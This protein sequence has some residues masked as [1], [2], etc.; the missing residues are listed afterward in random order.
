MKLKECIE[1]G[2]ECGLE[3]I[4]E[5]ILNVELHSASLF[6]I[7]NIAKEISELYNDLLKEEPNIFQKIINERNNTK[8]E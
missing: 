2:R 7:D 8:D 4:E 5:C 6:K 3:T 1:L